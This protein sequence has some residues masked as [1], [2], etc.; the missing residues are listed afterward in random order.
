ML[1]EM[2]PP[3]LESKGL[4][5]A[6]EARFDMVERRVGIRVDSQVAELPDVSWEVERQLYYV[7]IEALNNAFKHSQANQVTLA[8]TRE[9]NDVRLCVADHGRVGQNCLRRNHRQIV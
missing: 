9:V 5:G 2:Q 7:A 8:L 1:F 4:A 3:S 6:L